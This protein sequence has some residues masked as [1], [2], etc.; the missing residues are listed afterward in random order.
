VQT[1]PSSDAELINQQSNISGV[2]INEE[3]AQMLVFQQMFRRWPVSR[4]CPEHN[5]NSL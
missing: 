5:I 2:D 3:A 1:K 4:N